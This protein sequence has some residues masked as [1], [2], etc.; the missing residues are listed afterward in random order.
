[1]NRREFLNSL[2]MAA[3][4]SGLKPA[5]RPNILY[6][7]ADDQSYR[8]LG[9]YG[10]RPWSWVRTP[11]LDRLAD[12][13]VRFE[14]AYISPWCVPSRAM[15]LTGLQPHAIEGL[16]PEERRFDAQTCLFW[17][18]ELRRAGYDTSFI[19]KWHLKGYGD[20]IRWIVDDEIEELYDLWS[21]P[22]ELTNLAMD[23]RHRA[24]LED[25]RRRLETELRRTHAGIVNHLPAPRIRPKA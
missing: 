21:D 11:N 4:G 12:D 17:P 19:G 24:T 15:A 8:S 2:G 18:T 5:R 3:V 13:G 16:R 9:C 10:Y 1:M 22:G 20:Y 25:Y 23:P 7:F 6:I 14:Y